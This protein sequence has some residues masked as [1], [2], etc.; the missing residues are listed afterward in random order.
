MILKMGQGDNFQLHK[1]RNLMLLSTALLC[2][3][4]L[5]NGAMDFG[6]S[7]VYTVVRTPGSTPRLFYLLS[8]LLA[9]ARPSILFGYPL[10]VFVSSHVNTYPGFRAILSQ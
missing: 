2:L 8:L 6:N 4:T 10:Y 5:L 3:D 9:S 1:F 7:A